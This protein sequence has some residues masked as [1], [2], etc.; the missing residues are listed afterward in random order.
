M[1]KLLDTVCGLLAAVAL[2][3][4]MMLT[5]V[6][7]AGRKLLSTSVPGSLEVTELLM[8]AVIFAS[9][10]LVSLHGEHVLFDSL[11]H[12]LPAR[13]RRVQHA[14]VD[15]LCAGL[16]GGLAW[17]M[18]VKA[19]QMTSYGDTTAQLKLP[20]GPFVMAMSLLCAL[21]AAVQLGLVWR[22]AAHRPAGAEI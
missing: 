22:P 10:P 11:D 1:S 14:V 4:I 2:F 9:L 20:L 5:L 15:L 12:K 16:L 6:D 8:V 17:L 19:T 18:W 13:V 3:G 21:S 7:V